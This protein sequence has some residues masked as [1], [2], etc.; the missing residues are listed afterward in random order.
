MRSAYPQKRFIQP[1]EIAELVL[2]LCRDEAQSITGED[3]AI[4]TG[5]SW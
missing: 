3:I 2:Y 5:A 1:E 4:T